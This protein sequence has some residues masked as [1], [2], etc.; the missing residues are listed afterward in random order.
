MFS[1][2][3]CNALEH[4]QAGLW[5]VSHCG[6]HCP[7]ERGNGTRQRSPLPRALS[8]WS[9]GQEEQ[10]MVLVVGTAGDA[11]SSQAP[12]SPPEAITTA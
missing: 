10:L 11:W 9:S 1:E 12:G 3:L 4:G 7:V 2:A 6:S 5:P 8:R